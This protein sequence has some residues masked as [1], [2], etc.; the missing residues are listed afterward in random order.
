MEQLID[1]LLVYS[2]LGK[3]AIQR[4]PID[5][6][7]PTR[8]RLWLSLLSFGSFIF[9]AKRGPVNAS[10]LTEPGISHPVS[11]LL[12]QRVRFFHHL[13]QEAK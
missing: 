3:Q 2:K 1:D 10:L 9:L 6:E 11:L 8:R 13:T 4:A 5:T 12:A 7:R